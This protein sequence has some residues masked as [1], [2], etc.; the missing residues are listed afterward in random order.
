MLGMSL[1]SHT[2]VC[3]ARHIV[4]RQPNYSPQST[5]R[6]L[7]SLGQGYLLLWPQVRGRGARK[8]KLV[9][10]W[11]QV[12]TFWKPQIWAF[13]L[14]IYQQP[15]SDFMTDM[16]NRAGHP[17]RSIQH[18]ASL[19][20]FATF[21]FRFL[22]VLVLNIFWLQDYPK[23]LLTLKFFMKEFSRFLPVC[24]LCESVPSG[25]RSPEAKQLILLIARHA[26]W[27]CIFSMI[28]TGCLMSESDL[29]VF[30]F[31]ALRIHIPSHANRNGL[32]PDS[33]LFMASCDF[34]LTL[35][36]R[37]TSHGHRSHCCHCCDRQW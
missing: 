4:S 18:Q 1:I 10:K 15:R 13:V 2:L 7:W 5:P 28:P 12:K 30:G 34:G 9:L 11:G 35:Q 8:R 6:C 21:E 24:L 23:S 27:T 33:S 16:A 17:L 19:G 14:S 26:W 36:K 31:K 29:T 25:F 37:D 20:Y 3:I 22:H 32:S